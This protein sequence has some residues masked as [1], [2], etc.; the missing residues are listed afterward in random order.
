MTATQNLS[1]PQFESYHNH[2]GM[3]IR[4]PNESEDRCSGCGHRLSDP[5]TGKQP[6]ETRYLGPKRWANEIPRRMAAKRRS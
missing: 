5:V 4:L 2:G 6:V 3:R 1:G